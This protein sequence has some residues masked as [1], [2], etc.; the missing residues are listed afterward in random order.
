M[1]LAWCLFYGRKI[2]MSKAEILVT[3]LGEMKDM[4]ACLAIYNGTARFKSRST[5]TNFDKT[6]EV[7]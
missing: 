6:L 5:V 7:L 3:E 1:T 2:G 4:I